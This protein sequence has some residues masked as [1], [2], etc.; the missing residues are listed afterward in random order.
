MD[1]TISQATDS[2]DQA[3]ISQQ[4]VLT[5]Y[6]LSSFFHS[7]HFLTLFYSENYRFGNDGTALFERLRSDL[8]PQ[9]KCSCHYDF[10][11]SYPGRAIPLTDITQ[12]LSKQLFILANSILP[13]NQLKR[14]DKIFSVTR[15]NT[16][17]QA[18][19]VAFNF[20]IM[21]SLRAWLGERDRNTRLSSS[22]TEC[23]RE[24][25]VIFEIGKFVESMYTLA[26]TTQSPRFEQMLKDL[27]STPDYFVGGYPADILAHDAALLRCTDPVDAIRVRRQHASS[28]II[29]KHE[30]QA[31]NENFRYYRL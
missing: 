2:L 20:T 12:Q 26:Y 22:Y 16:F 8:Y 31:D 28:K 14:E 30:M 27:F 18:I 25:N 4:H 3:A 17:L 1:T 21:S 7:K 19:F 24:R 11:N 10:T 5:V 9:L 15:G 6:K 29:T 13:A 23:F